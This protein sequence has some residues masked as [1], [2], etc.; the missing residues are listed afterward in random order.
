MWQIVGKGSF[1]EEFVT[2]GGVELSDLDMRTMESRLV[3]GLFF[4][5][6][7]VNIDGVTGGF[8]F[9]SAWTTGWV[10][11]TAI[12]ARAAEAGE[13]VGAAGAGAEAAVMAAAEEA[14][15]AGEFEHRGS[16]TINSSIREEEDRKG[17]V[18]GT[19]PGRRKKAAA[20]GRRE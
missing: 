16:P 1:K 4:A 3:P 6:E 17:A 9:Q 8:N 14:V 19:G 13:G 11:G 7:V 2:C 15:A 12:G 10:A 20:G 18:G 5:G